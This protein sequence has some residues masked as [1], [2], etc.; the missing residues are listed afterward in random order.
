MS[1]LIDSSIMFTSQVP[2]PSPPLLRGASGREKGEGAGR[3]RRHRASLS[4]RRVRAGEARG[5]RLRARVRSSAPE[6]RA[7]PQGPDRGEP[8]QGEQNSL[9]LN[10]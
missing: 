10:V 5:R 3:S 1:F 2:T 9:C 6:G 8:G 7:D 4:L